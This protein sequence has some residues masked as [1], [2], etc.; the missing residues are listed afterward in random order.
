MLRYATQRFYSIFRARVASFYRAMYAVLPG[1]I[2]IFKTSIDC[3]GKHARERALP[4]AHA[5]AD[6]AAAGAQRNATAAIA[7]RFFS[8]PIIRLPL[9]LMP[10]MSPLFSLMLIFFAATLRVISSLSPPAFFFA[11]AAADYMMIDFQILSLR[12][13]FSPLPLFSCSLPPA[14]FIF[15]SPGCFLRLR[16]RHYASILLRRYAVVCLLLLPAD[17]FAA[18]CF[19][20][21]ASLIYVSPL[22]LMLISFI[23]AM[24]ILRF[25]DDILLLRYVAADIACHIFYD[26][27]TLLDYFFADCRYA[28]I[29][30]AAVDAAI[31]CCCITRYLP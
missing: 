14:P 16:F 5:R 12:F 26:F 15:A 7:L 13:R 24:L 6:I 19:F 25:S 17:S 4:P 1:N 22:M 21:F 3:R 10:L 11:D 20:A 28:A 31:C 8:L 18:A 23:A 29:D 9:P 30:A 2:D 27:F